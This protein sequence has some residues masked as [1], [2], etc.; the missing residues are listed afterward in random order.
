MSNDTPEN[1][2]DDQAS[3]TT[4]DAV[5]RTDLPA[6]VRKSFG[7]VSPGRDYSPNW[8][9]Q[10]ICHELEKVRRGETKR[11]AIAMPPRHLKSISASVAFP[12]WL[13]GHDPTREIICVSYAQRNSPLNTGQ[14]Y[15]GRI[16]HHRARVAALHVGRWCINRAGRQFD[17]HR[18]SNG[19]GWTLLNLPAI[20]RDAIIV[21]SKTSGPK[22]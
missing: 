10:A 15:R 2:C 7:T 14:E 16:Y 8:H 12:A 4:L 9:I 17:H 21:V 20:E 18:R 22:F 3:V 1:Y 5:L 13:L 19:E 11:L 6:F